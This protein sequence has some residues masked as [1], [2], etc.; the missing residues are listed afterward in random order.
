MAKDYTRLFIVGR[1]ITPK[2][3]SV[4]E[5]SFAK[6]SYYLYLFEYFK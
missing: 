5:L 2:H 6:A 4:P 1:K 3:L